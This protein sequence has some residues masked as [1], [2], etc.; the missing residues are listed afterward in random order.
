MVTTKAPSLFPVMLCKESH[1]KHIDI[2]YY[3]ILK[4]DII[5]CH[6][7]TKHDII[8]SH[9]ETKHDIIISH[10]ETKLMT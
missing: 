6:S 9:L 7:E 8:I 3:E 4:H 10:L 2:Q 5:I 1:T